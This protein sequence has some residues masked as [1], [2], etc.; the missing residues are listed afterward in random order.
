MRTPLAVILAAVLAAGASG[1]APPP[2]G[3]PPA[4]PLGR[5]TLVICP[6]GP[7]TPKCVTLR[8]EIAETSEARARGLMFRTSLDEFSG[9][10]FIFE[11]TTLLSFWMKNT[12]IPLSIAFI[13]EG[14]RIVDI[15]DMA[16]ERD[17]NTPQRFYPAVRPARYALEVN[18]GFFARHGIGVRARVTLT[19]Q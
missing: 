5:G 9:M 15:Q 6:E 2:G 3:P 12:L 7:G 4:L 8:V 1:A 13:D 19:R 11:Q 18:L 16:V 14:W 10:L 17:P